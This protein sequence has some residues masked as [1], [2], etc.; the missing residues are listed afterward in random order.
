MNSLKKELKALTG[1]KHGGNFGKGCR[2][3]IALPGQDVFH[4]M[5]LVFSVNFGR[6]KCASY[7]LGHSL[8]KELKKDGLHLPDSPRGTTP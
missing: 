3:R 8:L 1:G 2:G 6:C 7:V 4:R 5:Y